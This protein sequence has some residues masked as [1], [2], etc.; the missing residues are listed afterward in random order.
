MAQFM[1]EETRAQIMLSVNVVRLTFV[2]FLEEDGS[3]F[4][5]P[6]VAQ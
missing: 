4:G 3:I 5:G 6:T 1:A 2:Y